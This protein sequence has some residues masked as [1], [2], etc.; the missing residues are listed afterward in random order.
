MPNI[1][2]KARASSLQDLRAIAQSL[3]TKHLGM[4]NQVDTYF[5]TKAGRLKLREST[6]SGAYLIPYL[7]PDTSGP[8]K[9]D[10]DRLTSEDG[11]KTKDLFSK[12]LGTIKVIKKSRD[13]Y[14]INN[15]RVHLDDVEGLGTFLEFE[16]VYED[17]S[18][19]C[20]EREKITELLK[21]FNIQ[22]QDLITHSY[23][24]F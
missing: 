18:Q 3:A 17:S 19:E 12:I 20:S 15:V 9:S 14:L 11:K 22:D 16:A 21:A 13:I 23:S 10:Y 5:E 6:L 8:K 4:D 7:R 24:D 2:I 1:E